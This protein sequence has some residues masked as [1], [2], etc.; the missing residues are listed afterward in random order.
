[1]QPYYYYYR[2]QRD[3]HPPPNKPPVFAGAFFRL[4]E[5]HNFHDFGDQNAQIFFYYVEYRIY[6]QNVLFLAG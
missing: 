5:N 3:K 4:E 6:N 2:I 1:M